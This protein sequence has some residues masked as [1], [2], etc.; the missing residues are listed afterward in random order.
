MGWTA[1]RDRVDRRPRAGHGTRTRSG[2]MPRTERTGDG[3]VG[4]PPVHGRPVLVPRQVPGPHQEQRPVRVARATGGAA[5]SER[6]RLRGREHRPRAQHDGRVRGRTGRRTDRQDRRPDRPATVAGADAPPRR[7]GRATPGPP[8]ARETTSGP[9]PGRAEGPQA[10]GGHPRVH[11][12]RR[13]RR[14]VRARLARRQLVR[15]HERHVLDAQPEGIRRPA[16]A[17]TR[18]PGPRPA[19]D[20]VP[21]RGRGG[22]R[23][24]RRARPTTAAGAPDLEPPLEATG[25]ARAGRAADPH[26]ELLV[27]IDRRRDRSR[28][29]SPVAA[30][31]HG[32]RRRGPADRRTTPARTSGARW[33]TSVAP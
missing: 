8:A 17:R 16:Q 7:P 29:R 28:S 25:S 15:D 18:V 6:R 31:R 9:S 13:R 4:L 2:P 12:L 5:A 11:V 20:P 21:V 26:D 30:S 32:P 27:G 19:R 22:P 24:P 3:L 1:R 10:E 33:P 14:P 23:T